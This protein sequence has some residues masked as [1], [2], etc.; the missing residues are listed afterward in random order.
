MNIYDIAEMAKV[1]IATVS[2]VVNGSDKVSEKTRKKVMAVIEEVG[3][4][5]NVFAQGLGLNTMHTIGLLVPTISDLYMSS[6]VYYLEEKLAKY[7]YDCILGCSGFELEGKQRQTDMILSKHVDALILVGSTYAG[8]GERVEDTDYIR[9]AAEQ[10]PVFVVN[11]NVQGENVFVTVNDDVKAVYDVTVQMIE[12]GHERILFLTDSQSY[13][14]IKKRMG[15]EKALEDHRIPFRPELEMHVENTVHAVRD[16]LQ[17]CNVAFD[18]VI[19]SNDEIAVGALKYASKKGI[20]VPDEIAIVGYNNSSIGIA[21]EPELT[22]IDNH[23][24]QICHETVERLI[25]VIERKEKNLEHKIVIPCELVKRG[26][27]DF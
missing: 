17:N 14:A 25:A 10:V 3:Y 23:I 21:C 26:T 19:A 22:S 15:Y 2:R 18:A 5:P 8:N 24:E 27:T 12:H 9:E 1:S 20:L 7:G 6:A 4:T 11:G 13:S 16:L